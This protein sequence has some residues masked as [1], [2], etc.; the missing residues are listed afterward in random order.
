MEEIIRIAS[1]AGIRRDGTRFD[2][3]AYVDGQWV[4]FRRGMPRKIGG[5]RAVNRHMGDIPRALH[6]H[7][8]D[9]RTYVHAGSSTKLERL[10]VDNNGNSSVISDRTPAGL[11]ASSDNIWQMDVDHSSAGAPQILAQV[12]PNLDCLCNSAGGQLFYGGLYDTTALTELTAGAELPPAASVTGGVLSLH[13]YTVVFGNN[14]YVAWSMP[15]DCTD[16]VGTGSGDT[17]I[18]KQ[19]L[20]RGMPLRGGGSNSPA[21]LLWSADALMRMT[22]TG[23]SN[24]FAFDTISAQTSILSPRSVIEHDG[25]F[26]WLGNDRMLSFNGVVREVPNDYNLDFFYEELNRDASQK[27][28]AFKVPRYGEIWWCFPR[29][30]STE[31]NHAIIFNARENVWYDCALPESGRGDATTYG[32][33]GQPLASGVEELNYE[34]TEATASTAGTGYSAGD[35]LTI[36]GGTSSV[37]AEVTVE[38]VDGGGGVLTVSIANVGEYTATPSNPVSP[39]GGGGSGAELT[40]TFTQ[41]YQLWIHESGVDKVDGTTSEPIESYFET[42]EF[43]FPAMKGLDKSM[44]VTVVEPDFTQAGDLLMQIKG[45]AN[46]RASDV[47]GEEKTL[48]ES[49][50]TP[51]EQILTFKETFR[52]ARFKVTSNELGGDYKMGRVLAHIQPKDSRRT[53]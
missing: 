6:S 43:S 39:T 44:C 28:F 15:G 19:K 51:A 21:G 24:V 16:F 35:V 38:T 48:T 29:G 53:G 37:T 12:A 27:V 4:R 30:S 45:R 8:I 26:Y 11:D 5:Y 47:D 1:K 46:A 41:P 25:V 22:F 10:Y 50:A 42:S 32:H 34:L 2:N 17:Y 36:P 18:T 20:V 40:L 14:G 52:L 7:V 9:H 13:P 23:S 33:L 3:D 31:A 49:A